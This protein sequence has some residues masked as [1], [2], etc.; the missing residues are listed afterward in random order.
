M[1]FPLRRLQS[2]SRARWR[3]PLAAL[4]VSEARRL[5]EHLSRLDASGKPPPP[6]QQLQQHQQPVPAP[7]NRYA[8][9]P[10]YL[11][12]PDRLAAAEYL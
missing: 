11:G 10:L 6:A 2:R 3:D 4:M 1:K 12:V 7:S 9:S 5:S 8:A